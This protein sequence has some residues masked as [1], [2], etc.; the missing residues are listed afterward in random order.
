MREGYTRFNRAVVLFVAGLTVLGFAGAA[1]G[2]ESKP[3]FNVI[4]VD[5]VITPPVAS[6]IDRSINEAKAAGAEGLIIL[7]DTPGGLDQS[8]RNI[9]KSI[10]NAPIPVFVYVYP[11][12]ARAASAGAIITIAAHVAAMAPGTNIGAA[13]PV[14]IGLGGKMDET[15]AKK[16]ENDAAAY[17]ISIAQQKGRNAQWIES[18]IRKS[19][20]IPADEALKIG[21][22]DYV[23]PDVN[24]LLS[25]SDG[26]KVKVLQG[27]VVLKTKNAVLKYQK[28]GFRESILRTITDPNI[29]YILLLVGL[30]GL[31]F[32]FSTPGA[33]IPGV[34]GGICLI[35]AFFALQTL[36][37]NFAGIL[38]ILFAVILFIAEIKI[39]S[40]GILTIGGIISL[41]L[42]SLM[43]YNYPDA[44]I[45]V[46]L[47]VLVPTVIVISLFF[48]AVISLAVKAQRGKPRTGSEGLLGETGT[49]I[50]PVKEQG[51]IIVQGE[52]WNAFSKSG[53]E[54]G[55]RVKVVAV[56]GLV[57]EVEEIK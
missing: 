38:L 7:L 51:K 31:Y 47:Q 32:E 21:V 19:V 2:A 50:T 45:R 14:G 46:S 42:G 25:Q 9:V 16:V 30:A 5:A 8:M 49:A 3:V 24:N 35:L 53:I 48:I 26:R 22:V 4:T 40:H 20:S 39:V 27:T 52:Y 23:A 18:A 17:G 44:A 29:A 12:G 13:H 54:Q 28:M 56:K 15:M 36:S 1:P 6:Y 43:L 33:V 10:I 37:V 55:K 57:L 34:I 41:V 11:S